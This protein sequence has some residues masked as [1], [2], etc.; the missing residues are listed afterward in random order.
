MPLVSE[1]SMSHTE[2]GDWLIDC[3]NCILKKTS[4][5]TDGDLIRLVKSQFTF[6]TS[7]I[8]MVSQYF[9]SL[10]K[11]KFFYFSIDCYSIPQIL[12]S[13]SNHC[14]SPSDLFLKISIEFSLMCLSKSSK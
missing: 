8:L 9:Q 3:W 11:K 10:E 13:R 14:T 7:Q 4:P 2:Y 12:L 5:R 6:S 1:I